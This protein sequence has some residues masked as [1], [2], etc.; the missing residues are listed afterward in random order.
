[1]IRNFDRLEFFSILWALAYILYLVQFSLAFATPLKIL[2]LLSAMM[3]V[4]TPNF[5]IVFLLFIILQT[6]D[7]L[8]QLPYIGEH[9]FLV[10]FVDLVIV[11]AFIA[12]NPWKGRTHFER[13]KFLNEFSLVV[14]TGF[15]IFYFFTA[16][17]KL[18]SDFLSYKVSCGAQHYLRLAKKF[19]VLSSAAW[20]QSAAIYGTILMEWTLP[21]LLLFSPTRTAGVVLGILFHFLIGINSF[22]KIGFQSFSSTLFALFLLFLPRDSDEPPVKTLRRG[23]APSVILL[24][25][26][27]VN[28]LCPY[29]GLK[30][31]GVFTMHSNL[32]TE[33]GTSNHLF[34]PTFLQIFK[35]Q[36]DLVFIADSSDPFLRK[37]A[38]Q[39][40]RL[41]YFVLRSY[42]SQAAQRGEKNIEVTFVREGKTRILNN[43]EKDPELSKPYPFLL[44]KWMFF[45]AVRSERDLPAEC[46]DRVGWDE[47]LIF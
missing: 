28:G 3:V 31:A 21:L 7:I 29:L 25:W 35:F 20:A 23:M 40:N 13:K 12:Q 5:I 15:L 22:E 26:V 30:T 6:A 17:A 11:F 8:N 33:G 39:R 19:P 2:T 14:C 1:M 34:I 10:L 24:I 32:R 27:V 4:I 44:R 38:K 18:N 43:A 46:N 16:L 47:F 45:R 9:L 42:I 37:H 36:R 41:P